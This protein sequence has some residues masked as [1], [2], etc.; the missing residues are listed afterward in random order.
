MSIRRRNRS[1]L[2][3][4]SLLRSAWEIHELLGK[5]Y[6]ARHARWVSLQGVPFLVLLSEM[7]HQDRSSRF[8]P[9]WCILI[10]PPSPPKISYFASIDG[11]LHEQE[12]ESPR[13]HNNPLWKFDSVE[14]HIL[15]LLKLWSQ[16]TSGSR[17][18]ERQILLPHLK[19]HNNLTIRTDGNP[20]DHSQIWLQALGARQ[21]QHWWGRY[22]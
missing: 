5:K 17:Y 11:R 22:R 18:L 14:Y 13:A 6:R 20:D 19:K 12:G 21:V 4:D 16:R 3:E 1:N 8:L 10:K 2:N 7:Y 9:K 15:Y